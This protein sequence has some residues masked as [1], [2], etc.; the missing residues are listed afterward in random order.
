MIMETEPYREQ[1]MKFWPKSGRCILA[2]YD[3]Q[4]VTVYQAYCP[5][6]AEWAVENQR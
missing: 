6:I 1:T 5:E 4:S 3:D 2:Q